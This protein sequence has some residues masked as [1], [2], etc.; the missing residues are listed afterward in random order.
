MTISLD[1][2]LELTS[3]APLDAWRNVIDR[4]LALC[5]LPLSLDSASGNV[6]KRDRAV[7]EVR[8]FSRVGSLG[9]VAQ[10]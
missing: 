2:L 1:L 3:A 10:F 5:S 9:L 4:A 8:P 7:G 6:T